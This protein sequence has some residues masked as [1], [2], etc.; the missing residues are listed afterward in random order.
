LQGYFLPASLAGLWGYWAAGLWTP[1]VSRFYV[2]SLP[3]VMAGTFLGRA[4]HHR[5]AAQRFA[6]YI[7]AGLIAIG[8]ILLLQAMMH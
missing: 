6:I 8:V 5:I 7:H 2:L 1:A 3:V 4:I